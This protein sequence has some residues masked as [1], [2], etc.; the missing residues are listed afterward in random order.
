MTPL[1]LAVG[2]VAAG[3]LVAAPGA[4]GAVTVGMVAPTT[5]SGI[6]SGP[7]DVIQD[8][9]GV[10]YEIPA[11]IASP[12]VT[13]W[14]T[15]AAPGAGQQLT[16]ALFEVVDESMAIYRQVAHDGPQSLT[17]G[18][19]N[20]FRTKLP[21]RAGL[22]L[23]LGTPAG[24]GPTGCIFGSAIGS[25]TR[26]SYFNDG[27]SG[28]FAAQVGLVNVSAVIEPSNDFTIGSVHRNRKKGTAKVDVT[29][30]GPGSLALSGKGIRA[31]QAS[32]RGPLAAKS[33]SSGGTVKVTVRVKG[34]KRQRLNR[35]GRVKVKVSLTYTPTGGTPATQKRKLKLRRS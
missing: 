18:T 20:T 19:L 12:V 3:V 6:C 7:N 32:G 16:L 21:A 14:S 4:Q 30:P 35:T 33:V 28:Q 1:R 13:S 5:P 9:P 29:V 11:G 15:N 25:R 10:D 34:R 22:F 17:G 8:A 26:N 27:D 31:Q 2:L 24:S 23:G